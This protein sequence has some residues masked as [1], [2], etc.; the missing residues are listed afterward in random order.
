MTA[1]EIINKFWDSQYQART[2]YY[3][4]DEVKAFE[5]ARKMTTACIRFSD[6][7]Q[8]AEVAPTA[9]EFEV[10][11]FNIIRR[12]VDEVDNVYASKI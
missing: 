1:I 6:Y 5:R 12:K 10:N 11:G 8:L 7:P 4:A 2:R 3:G 9:G